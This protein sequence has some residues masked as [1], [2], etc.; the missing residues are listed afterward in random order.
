MKR[1][2]GGLCSKWEQQE[3]KIII[4]IFII[5]PITVTARSKAWTIFSHSNAGI[6]GSNPT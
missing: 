6:V 5:I 2:T 1:F 3:Q 4:I